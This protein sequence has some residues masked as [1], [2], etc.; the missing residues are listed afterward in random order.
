MN[1]LLLLLAIAAITFAIILF[2]ARPDLVK[3][4]W[5]WAVGLAGPIVKAGSAIVKKIKA[6]FRPDDQTEKQANYYA[7]QT[8]HV[9]ES[10]G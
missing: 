1:R 10:Q 6:L 5:L 7:Q 9:N 2:A 3:E 4:F 8:R